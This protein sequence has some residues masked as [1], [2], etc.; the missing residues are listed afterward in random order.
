ME[1]TWNKPNTIARFH[2]Y[3]QS[4]EEWSR[5]ACTFYACAVNLKYNCW[6]ELTEEDIKLIAA[7][8]A[9]KWLFSYTKGW[10]ASDWIKAVY[11]FVKENAKTRGWVVP[12]LA[13]T[14]TDNDLDELIELGYAVIVWIKVNSNFYPAAKSWEL[15]KLNDYTK[16]KWDIW[17]FTNI[18][19]NRNSWNE[20]V[21]DS[22]FNLFKQSI[23]Y[24]DID[25][26][27]A[28]LDLSTKY[29]FF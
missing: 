29:I 19:K 26:L 21:I 9:K 24:V 15:T 22:F 28:E 12:N 2:D 6:I 13:T 17:H 14:K 3:D 7:N 16:Y 25:E 4:D 20:F 18:A 1:I 23:Y 8:Q 10:Y 5:M 11:W 27:L